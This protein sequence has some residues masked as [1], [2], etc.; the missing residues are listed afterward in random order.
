MKLYMISGSVKDQQDDKVLQFVGTQKSAKDTL[1]LYK[2]V[3]SIFSNL[4]LEEVDVPT[5][6]YGL[7]GWLNKFAI[8]GMSNGGQR[9]DE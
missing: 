6:K 4:E 7:I 9:G 8:Y 2:S 5:D 3:P 1:R